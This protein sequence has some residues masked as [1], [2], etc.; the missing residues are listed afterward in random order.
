MLTKTSL[1]IAA[2]L[3]IALG[4]IA[5][6]Q[7]MTPEINDGIAKVVTAPPQGGR[8]VMRHAAPRQA[9]TIISRTG[10]TGFY[11]LNNSMTQGVTTY[12]RCKGWVGE[13]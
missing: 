7:S 6:A 9:A 13:C 10:S 2:G 3:S 4:G 12:P 5:S 11:Q 8:L 1:L